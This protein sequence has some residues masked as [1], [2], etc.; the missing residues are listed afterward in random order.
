MAL[1]SRPRRL[2]AMRRDALALLLAKTRSPAVPEDWLEG[3]MLAR[4]DDSRPRTGFCGYTASVRTRAQADALRDLGLETIYVPLDVAAQTGLPVILPRVFSDAEQGK[5]EML[6]GQA[7]SRGTRVVLAGNIGQVAMARRLGFAVR[8]DFGLNAF[9]SKTLH[10]LAEMGVQRQTL[11]FEARLAQIRDMCGPLETEMIVYGYL[12]LMIFENCAIR[13]QHGGKCSCENGVTY[14]T[15]RRGERF[16]LLPEYGCR[17]TLLGNRA[18]C[19][20]EDVRPLGVQ[21]ARLLFTTE[22]P[23]ECVRIACAFLEGNPLEG[24]FTNGLYKRGVE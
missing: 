12:P 7:M 11:S 9:N 14:L 17:N 18:L 3:S 24:E 13:R 22:S 5:I 23:E 20:R 2:T 15:D 6:L 19:L 16:A 8:G 1:L 4:D 10:A 21:T